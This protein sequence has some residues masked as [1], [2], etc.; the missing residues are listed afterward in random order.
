[1][2]TRLVGGGGA[3]GPITGSFFR[4]VAPETAGGSAGVSA[5]D[6]VVLPGLVGLPDA[7][8]LPEV[9][10]DDVFVVDPHAPS[11][12]AAGTNKM[13]R[14]RRTPGRLPNRTT[15]RR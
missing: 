7:V 9:V 11:T 2:V 4:F 10:E 8:G 1:L 6:D 5:V 15:R 3:P 14:S 12:R 13:M